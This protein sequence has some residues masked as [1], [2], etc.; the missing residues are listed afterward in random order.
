M[1]VRKLL[2]ICSNTSCKT[3][4]TASKKSR[5][6][7]D[8]IRTKFD[9]SKQSLL[10]E[11]HPLSYEK[12]SLLSAETTTSKIHEFYHC[13]RAFC[14]FFDMRMVSF[15]VHARP[16]CRPNVESPSSSQWLVSIILAVW[17][18]GNGQGLLAGNQ[19]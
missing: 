16:G 7:F 1:N 6:S 9:F 17:H 10:Y 13:F 12:Q 18:P 15:S 8:E 3:F 19:E 14:G 2:E 4:E 5:M 11:Q